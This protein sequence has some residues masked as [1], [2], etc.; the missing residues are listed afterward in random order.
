M[1]TNK[2]ASNDGDSKRKKEEINKEKGKKEENE[3]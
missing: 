3:N 2:L 1:F